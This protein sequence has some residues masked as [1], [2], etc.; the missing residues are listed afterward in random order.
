MSVPRI[1]KLTSEERRFRV[2][3]AGKLS[4]GEALC[5]FDAVPPAGITLTVDALVLPS[6]SGTF[7]VAGGED[8]VTYPITVSA[9][10]SGG[11]LLG[12]TID[13]VTK[14]R[15]TDH[16]RVYGVTGALPA[17]SVTAVATA[18]RSETGEVSV[19]EAE[20]PVAGQV[21]VATAPT[22]AEWQSPD[23]SITAGLLH[24]TGYLS[25]FNDDTKRA[26]ARTNLALQNIDG[27]TFQ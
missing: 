27:G 19:W 10:T 24:T 6:T 25:E 16:E 14:A 21:L 17:I 26:A 18:L 5:T 23:E 9:T 2:E 20:A 3:F 13:L 22:S 15:M 4:A 12:A 11:Q 7:L 1:A 8:G